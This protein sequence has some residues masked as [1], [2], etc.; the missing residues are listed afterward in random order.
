M[1]IA[2]ITPGR[3]VR[4][5][6]LVASYE[7]REARTGTRYLRMSLRD[8]AGATIDAVFFQVSDAQIAAVTA[9]E[10]YEVE[11]MADEFR[12]GS[13]SRSMRCGDRTKPGTRPPIC[14]GR[15]RAPEN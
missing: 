14:P 9:G 15:P 2:D 4:G 12:N 8:R 6:F 11:G 7:V 1:N 10:P 13:T 5:V 3:I